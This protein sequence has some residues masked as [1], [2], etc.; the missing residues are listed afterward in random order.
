[1]WYIHNS[2][3]IV[4]CIYLSICPT[5]WYIEQGCN[6]VLVG[7]RGNRLDEIKDKLSIDFPVIDVH[8][9]VLDVAD[10]QQV[11]QLPMKLPNAFRNVDLLVN[12]AGLALGVTAVQENSISDA[13]TV[14]NTNVLGTIAFC[15]AFIPG[16]VA[17]GVGHVVNIGSCAG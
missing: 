15:S 5:I 6:L 8:T 17:R 2:N 12:N 11:E 1:M 9:V 4:L 7:R 14:M 3:L 16:M 13:A 10:V